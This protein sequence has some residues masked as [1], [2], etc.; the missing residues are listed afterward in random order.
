M[1]EHSPSRLAARCRNTRPDASHEPFCFE[2]F[3]RAIVEGCSLSWTFL[4]NQYYSLVRYWVSRRTPPD[5]DAIDDLTQEAF[6]AFWRFYTP[7]KLAEAG[8]LGNVLAYMKSCAAS[9]VA[10]ERRKADG[11]VPTTPGSEWVVD[12][13]VSVRSAE[14]SALREMNAKDLWTVI[15][16]A[17]NDEREQL[18]ARLVF[19]LDLKPRDIAARFPKLFPDVSEVYRVKRNL[20]DRLRRDPILRRIRENGRNERLVE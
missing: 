6:T 17:C 3:R 16:A 14:A 20:L 12:A 13:C 11:R 19:K 8:R 1:H 5:P 7:D 9:V 2:L 15:E 4:H 10:Q 18:V